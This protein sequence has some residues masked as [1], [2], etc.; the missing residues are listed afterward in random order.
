MNEGQPRS[1]G[2]KYFS[3]PPCG[4]VLLVPTK[5]ARTCFFSCR[6]SWNACLIGLA[7]RVKSRWYVF[8]DSSTNSSTC[9]NGNGDSMYT[10]WS[11]G[12]SGNDVFLECSCRPYRKRMSRTRQSLPPLYEKDSSSRLSSKR[13]LS[14]SGQAHRA[15]HL[16]R[17]K[18]SSMIRRL[19]RV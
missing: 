17:S 11:V 15:A 1:V 12:G 8:V 5:M 3:V 9:G 2:S 10:D 16:Y 6:Y 4:S 19:N 13:Q 14:Y 7:Y 18:A